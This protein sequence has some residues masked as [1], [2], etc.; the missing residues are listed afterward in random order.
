MKNTIKNNRTAEL[1]AKKLAEAEALR[2]AE[3]DAIQPKDIPATMDDIKGKVAHTYRNE[4]GV[5]LNVTGGAYIQIPSGKGG[6]IAA[7]TQEELDA[8]KARM[9]RGIEGDQ[10][11]HKVVVIN[12]ISCECVGATEEELEADIKAAENYAKAHPTHMLRDTDVAEQLLDAEY[13]KEDLEQVEVNGKTYLVSYKEKRVMNLDGT[14]A[15]NLEDIPEE[16]SRASIKTILVDRLS[17]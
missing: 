9:E 12:G 1:E 5:A 16:L 15:A 8:I 2:K 13:K 4:E 11:L 6:T 3:L 7:K 17:K 10:L 14:T